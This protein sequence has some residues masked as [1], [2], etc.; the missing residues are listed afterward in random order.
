MSA[1]D[2]AT[3]IISTLVLMTVALLAIWVP[4]QRASGVPPSQALRAE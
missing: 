1:L 4:S 3:L 2:P